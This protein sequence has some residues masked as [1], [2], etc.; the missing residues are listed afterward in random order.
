MTGLEREVIEEVS[1]EIDI[2][3]PLDVHHFTR[4][5]DQTITMIIFLCKLENDNVVL[6]EEHTEY[7]WITTDADQNE[8]PEWI[9]SIINKYQYLQ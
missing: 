9:W 3:M 5:D 4:D 1:L 7:K 2:V 8:F 6:S